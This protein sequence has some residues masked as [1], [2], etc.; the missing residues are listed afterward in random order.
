M[1]HPD[2]YSDQHRVRGRIPQPAVTTRANPVTA[3][4]SRLLHNWAAQRKIAELDGLDDA[5]LQDIGLN[6]SDL[7]W[8]SRLPLSINA[9][10]ALEQRAR[11]G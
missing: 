6:R 4:I 2:A 10:V 5:L 8:A 1:H 7:H 3:S 11:R 9:M